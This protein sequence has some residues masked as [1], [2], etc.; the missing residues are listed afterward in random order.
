MLAEA[1]HAAALKL[2]QVG[3]FTMDG[4]ERVQEL[5]FL[6]VGR[7]AHLIDGAADATGL[8]FFASRGAERA[9]VQEQEQ[10]ER[11]NQ[12]A[13]FGGGP[14]CTRSPMYAPINVNSTPSAESSTYMKAGIV[15]TV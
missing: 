4:F 5:A 12:S 13:A 3:G 1:V 2:A 15:F 11:A 8:G 9:P 10:N 14:I 6:R 7:V